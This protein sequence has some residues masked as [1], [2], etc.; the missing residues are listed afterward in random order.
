M[1]IL[2]ICSANKQR[3]KTAE[4]YFAS[5]FPEH[6]FLSAGTNSK[7]CRKEGTTELTEVLLEWADKVYAMEK[8]H[9][10][11]IQKHTGSKYYTK[12]TVLNI[13]DIYGYYDKGLLKILDER[14]ML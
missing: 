9:L 10:D 7:I 14:I 8:K 13:P 3:S 2:F 5:K 11:Q 1:R 4:D 6:E 12:V